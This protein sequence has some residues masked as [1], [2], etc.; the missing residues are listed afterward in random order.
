MNKLTEFLTFI[1]VIDAHDGQISLTNLA[2]IVVLVKIAIAPTVSI[3]DAGTLFVSL[4]AYSGKK[5]INNQQM[6]AQAA[7]IDTTAIEKSVSQVTDQME[8]MKSKINAL[9]MATGL[10]PKA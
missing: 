7:P 2:L 4:L 10:K 9:T 3:V 6:N 5:V 8:A 1:K